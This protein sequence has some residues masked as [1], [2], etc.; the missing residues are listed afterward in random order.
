MRWLL[1]SLTASVLGWV[2]GGTAQAQWDDHKAQEEYFKQLREQQKWEEKLAREDPQ[3][4]E[5]YQDATM[6]WSL[7]EGGEGVWGPMG[8]P[9]PGAF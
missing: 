9:M 6:E 8:G 1:S 4:A 2:L 7:W 5:M 3:D